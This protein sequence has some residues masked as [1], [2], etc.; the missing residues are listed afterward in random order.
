[1]A[2]LSWIHFHPD[3]FWSPVYQHHHYQRFLVQPRSSMM[4][5]DI[6]RYPFYVS[7]LVK[8]RKYQKCNQ[9]GAITYP[10]PLNVSLAGTALN[11][12]QNPSSVETILNNLE[13]G[14]CTLFQVQ[15]LMKSLQ[16]GAV[17]FIKPIIFFGFKSNFVML[18][19]FPFVSGVAI[20]IKSPRAF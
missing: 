14:Y 20:P 6:E 11:V 16:L 3:S 10:T 15:F 1:M 4:C 9:L 8:I 17:L 12:Q 5:L 18:I 19:S 13:H 2:Q 7:I